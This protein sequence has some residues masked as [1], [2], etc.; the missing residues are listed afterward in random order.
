MSMGGQ[1]VGE[2]REDLRFA[3]RLLRKN[4][5]FTCV[6]LL[7]LALSI[8]ANT[9]IFSVVNGA[10]LRPPPFSEPEQ[11]FQ[12]FGHMREGGTIPLSHQQ[13]AFLIEQ[14][15]PFSRLTAFRRQTVGFNLTSENLLES[16]PGGQVT[17]SFFEVLGV[18]PVLGRGFLPEEDVKGAARVVVLSHGLWQRLF[19][20]SPTVLGRSIHLNKEP[21]TIVG[22]VPPD[23]Q[24]P[25]E[26]QLWTPLRLDMTSAEDLRYLVV[27][28]RLKPGVEPAQVGARIKAQGDQLRV[29]RPGTLPPEHWLD[30][31][32]LQTL[33][34]ES[35]RPTLLVLLGAVAMVLLI[36]CVNLAN[37]Q[38]ARATRRG[39]ELALRTALGAR[40]GRIARQLLT[41][42][43]LLSAMGGALGLL[44]AGWSLPA[45]LALAP[46]LPPLPERL[47]L[48][49]T[50]LA[51]TFG[52]SVLTGLLF[53]L[54]PAW[55]A[56]RVDPH[57][58]LQVGAWRA[59]SR[60]A[61]SRTRRLLVVSQVALA[62]ILLIGAA[63]LL[64]SFAVLSSV[65]PGLDPAHVLTMKMT[66][67]EAPYADPE[68]FGSFNRRML[69]RVSALPGVEAAGFSLSLPF[70]AGNWIDV[71]IQQRPS[72]PG[73][74]QDAGIALF[75]PV[76]RGYF[77]ALKIQLVRG[78]LLDDQDQPGSPPVALINESAARRY[79]P[80]QDPIGKRVIL[81]RSPLHTADPYPREI[82]GVVKDVRELGLPHEPPVTFYIPLWQVPGEI[83]VLALRAGPESLLV[84]ASG[85]PA[86]LAQAVQRE[87]RAVDPLQPVMSVRTLEQIMSRSVGSQR[88]NTLLLGFMAGL[89]LVLAAVGIYGVLAQWVSQ[90]TR[91]LGVRMALGATRGQVVW[92]VLRQGMS[93][94]AVGVGL[95]VVGALGLT[96]LISHL[97][98]SVSPL[99]PAVFVAAPAV[100]VLVALGATWPPA[101]RATRVNPMEALRAE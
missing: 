78:R 24:L 66:L 58:P 20:G 90:R 30:A 87:L 81:G 17:H 29:S 6:A 88:F 46:Q 39:R 44:L 64:K 28:G 4:P 21:H 61:E 53:G 82:I 98:Y 101:R 49:K 33:R 89:A 72:T 14:S 48:D 22:V 47:L 91:E 51:F 83:L 54:L 26:A 50:V 16:V 77:D 3:L 67:H 23:I 95:G 79:W 41:E 34:T 76:T 65:T 80:G 52:V 92:L 25:A 13:Y 15:E 93:L 86:S 71:D 7:T 74:F 70:E 94:V 97:L 18:R 9:A 36:A 2:V 8:G 10:L 69:E 56:S 96:R 84:R 100:L 19:G 55:Q 45:L 1:R 73:D 11:I 35:V 32:G 75:R 62:V 31:E 42:S 59:T 37:L 43:V 12:V 40:P 27:L 5:G 85:E 63:L 60:P 68:V 38:L 99:D 57:G